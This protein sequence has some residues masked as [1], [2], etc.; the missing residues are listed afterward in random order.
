M[1]GASSTNYSGIVQSNDGGYNSKTSGS[2]SSEGKRSND[3]GFFSGL[4]NVFR[5]LIKHRKTNRVSQAQ[6]LASAQINNADED[7]P[8]PK[9][10]RVMDPEVRKA[11]VCSLSFEKTAIKQFDWLLDQFNG[12]PE[13]DILNCDYYRRCLNDTPLVAKNKGIPVFESQKAVLDFIDQSQNIEKDYFNIPE[14]QLDKVVI[15][16]L[17]E[18]VNNY[19][20]FVGFVPKEKRDIYFYDL[21]R[22][23]VISRTEE[24]RKYP[25]RFF[26]GRIIPKE[27]IGNEVVDALFDKDSWLEPNFFAMP[28]CLKTESICIRACKLDFSLLRFVPESLKEN[29]LNELLGAC[30]SIGLNKLCYISEHLITEDLLKKLKPS[31]YDCEIDALVEKIKSTDFSAIKGRSLCERLIQL[32]E[33]L[34]EYLP[35]SIKQQYKDLLF[36]KVALYQRYINLSGMNFDQPQ[37]QL[38]YLCSINEWYITLLKEYHDNSDINAEKLYAIAISKWDL[39]SWKVPDQYKTKQLVYW[40]IDCC[41][42][43]RVVLNYLPKLTSHEVRNAILDELAMDGYGSITYSICRDDCS[44]EDYLALIERMDKFELKSVFQPDKVIENLYAKE[45]PDMDLIENPFLQALKNTVYTCREIEPVNFTQGKKIEA[46]LTRLR[47]VDFPHLRTNSDAYKLLQFINKV[48]ICGGRTLKVSQGDHTTYF[49]FQRK[50]EPLETLIREYAMH[51]ACTDSELGLTLKSEVPTA[52]GFFWLALD[53]L[54]AKCAQF[55]D[56]LSVFQNGNRHY[57]RLYAYQASNAYSHY[58]HTPLTGKS[59]SESKAASDQGLLK[60]QWDIGRLTGL[61]LIPTSTLPAF[62]D[63]HSERRWLALSCLLG[64]FKPERVNTLPGSF[65]AWNTEATER[66]DFGI[67]GLR[68]FGDTEVYGEIRSYFGFKDSNEINHPKIVAQRLAYSN[69]IIENLL[70]PILIRARMLQH[71]PTYHYKNPA[72]IAD[73]SAFL[74]NSAQQF[75][76]GFFETTPLAASR[77]LN[78]QSWLGINDLHYQKWLTRTAEEILYWTALQPNEEGFD[79][80]EKNAGDFDP[81]DCYGNHINETKAFSPTL[82]SLLQVNTSHYP[83]DFLNADG[84]QNLGANNRAFPLC[85]LLKGYTLAC[86]RLLSGEFQKMHETTERLADTPDRYV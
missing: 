50:N 4:N 49:K 33:Q 12:Y 8:P 16:R 34:L 10:R 52:V 14:S 43:K 42:G 25:L 37:Q 44:V 21:L 70:A 5:T 13:H 75:L 72:V 2:A 48:Q 85:S 24:I 86:A 23:Q 17:I 29:V 84:K 27:L 47:S 45:R 31:G 26:R 39:Q 41:I 82:Y 53:E 69:A 54:P 9:I 67:T 6:G 15:S 19:G 35:G 1:N 61:G 30:G 22:Q 77:Q 78:L 20:R 28:D 18:R 76:L 66:P 80:L 7:Q 3:S 46:F 36:E 55:D 38:E 59:I 74:E 56:E 40:L 60:A 73:V 68:D 71:T 11:F 64:K 62:H 79:R 57:V 32:D 65:R 83:D 81:N 58:A 51:Q 63:A